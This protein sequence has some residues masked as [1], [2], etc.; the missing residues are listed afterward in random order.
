VAIVLPLAG[1]VRTF[2]LWQLSPNPKQGKD[3]V[4]K[5]AEQSLFETVKQLA[6]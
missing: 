3:K 5:E 1:K 4:S 6:R 2:R